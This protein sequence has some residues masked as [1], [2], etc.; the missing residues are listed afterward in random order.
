LNTTVEIIA[1]MTSDRYNWRRTLYL[2]YF[3]R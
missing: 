1:I 3:V 2:L